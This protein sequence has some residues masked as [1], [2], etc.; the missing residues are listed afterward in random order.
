MIRMVVALLAMVVS[1]NASETLNGSAAILRGLDKIS[2]D[3]GDIEVSTGAAG[4]YGRMQIEVSECRYPAAN[5]SGD[6]FAYLTIHQHDVDA[7]VFQG[8]MIASAP[9]LNA[10]DHP[11][12]D[13]W[14]LRCSTS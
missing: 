11:R 12:Y 14:L 10:L 8:W 5:P 2:G 1:A 13:I 9:A 4:S 7:P 3:V 6:A